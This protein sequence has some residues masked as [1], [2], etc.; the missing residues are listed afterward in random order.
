MRLSIAGSYIRIQPQPN[1]Q[2]PTTTST[3]SHQQRH[4][5]LFGPSCV[6]CTRRAHL[7]LVHACTRPRDP[8]L[9]AQPWRSGDEHH[10]ARA[11]LAEWRTRRQRLPLARRLCRMLRSCLR[12]PEEVGS[13]E[14]KEFSR[15][16][17]GNWETESGDERSGGR[18]LKV[19]EISTRGEVMFAAVCYHMQS[20]LQC[21]ALTY[22]LRYLRFV[23]IG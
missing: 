1:P 2:T 9:A 7:M 20:G 15:I 22:I 18:R 4:A 19:R 17:A 21:T 12:P 6:H 23:L 14:R 3:I 5:M 16:R 11:G 8:V 10:N 13:G